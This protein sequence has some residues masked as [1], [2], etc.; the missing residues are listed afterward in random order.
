MICTYNY[1]ASSKV[2]F[3]CVRQINVLDIYIYS[4]TET[5]AALK[6]LF[7][8]FTGIIF[9]SNQTDRFVSQERFWGNALLMY[10]AQL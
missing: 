5:F 1:D 6:S 10:I 4:T 8:I 9:P 2:V 3:C 7:I